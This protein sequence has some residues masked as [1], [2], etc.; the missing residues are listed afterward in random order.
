MG[1]LMLLMSGVSADSTPT[2]NAKYGPISQNEIW[3]KAVYLIGD[4][5]IPEGVTVTVNADTTVYFSN[6][7]LL[8]MGEDPR[9]CEIHINGVFHVDSTPENPVVF[10]SLE[11]GSIRQIASSGNRTTVIEL[12][13][14]TINTEILRDE[15]Q[16]FK[17]EYF[18]FW[19]IVYALW[20][21]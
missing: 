13:P 21:L 14:Y 10:Q 16:A 5:T 18:I 7:D 4:V 12:Q 6:Y 9:Q 2:L 17:N 1:G 15:F 8:Q 11:D 19:G 3:D 20:F